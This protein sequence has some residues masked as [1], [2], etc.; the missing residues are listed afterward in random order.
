MHWL[1]ILG[2]VVYSLPKEKGNGYKLKIR[3]FFNTMNIQ[4]SNLALANLL[5]ASS[6]L[7]KQV[8][9]TFT[10]YFLA[11]EYKSFSHQLI[12]KFA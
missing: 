7:K 1:K 4:G 12:A 2:S 8:E 5:N 11:S 10:C 6:F 9:I 3:T